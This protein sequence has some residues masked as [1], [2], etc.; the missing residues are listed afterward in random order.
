VHVA[1]NMAKG[2]VGWVMAAIGIAALAAVGI[3]A[4]I[5]AVKAGQNDAAEE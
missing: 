3:S 4:G 5:S 2:P 1:K